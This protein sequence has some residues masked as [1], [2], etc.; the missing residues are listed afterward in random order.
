[1][2]SILSKEGN[3]WSHFYK[4]VKRRKG[5]GENISAIKDSNGR[6]IRD[7]IEKANTFNSYYT[8][9]C[10]SEGNIPHI[11]G[12]NTG[13]PFTTDMKTI[14]RRIKAIGKTNQ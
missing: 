5:N 3:C 14:R 10:R 8:M 4:N 9:V 7:A 6:I 13:D 2:K 11:R 12:E 1:M